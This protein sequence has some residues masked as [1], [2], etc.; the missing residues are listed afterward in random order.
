M[1]RGCGR[2]RSTSSVPSP[3]AATAVRRAAVRAPGSSAGAGDHPHALAAAAGR[4]LDEDGEPAL[5]Q[6]PDELVVGHAWPAGPG[7]HGHSRG[8]HRRLGGDLVAHRVDRLRGRPD[9]HQARRSARAGEARVLREEP[10]A[11]VDRLRPGAARRRDQRAGV[12][13]ALKRGGR[14]DPDR[15]VGLEHVPGAGVRVAVHRDAGDAERA[16]RADDAD[17]DLA[18]VG[19]QN[20]AEHV[21]PLPHLLAPHIRK[22][23]KPGGASG[24]LAAADRDRPSTRRV[25]AGSM[26]P[27]SHS[28][29]VE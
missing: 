23:P 14:T 29:A 18:A 1:C 7:H 22:T 17:G 19:D 13:V 6:A 9:E 12:Q 25:S 3:N 21:V 16:Q 11:G 15:L 8:G 27:S 28:R 4:R 26:M 2:Y 5:V 20:L 10:V 24:A